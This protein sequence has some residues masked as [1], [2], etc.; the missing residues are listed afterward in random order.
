M[1]TL[2]RALILC[3]I[4]GAGQARSDERP[5]LDVDQVQHLSA[6]MPTEGG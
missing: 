3:R 2:T 4:K 1:R 5:L 6:H